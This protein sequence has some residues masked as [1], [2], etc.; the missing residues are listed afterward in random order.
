MFHGAI[1]IKKMS[2]LEKWVLKN[3]K[4]PAGDYRDW[5]AI[6]SWA[7]AIAGQLKKQG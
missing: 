2:F 7:R 6:T 4:A 5:E 3:V 1:D